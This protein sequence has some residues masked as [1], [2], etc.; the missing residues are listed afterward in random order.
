MKVGVTGANGFVGAHLIQRLNEAGHDV[1]ALVRNKDTV[2]NT[3]SCSV[4]EI[5]SLNGRVHVTGLVAKL[6]GLDILFHLAAHVH[7]MNTKDDDVLFHDVNVAGSQRLF[8]A[9]NTAGVKRFIFL[10]SVKAAGECSDDTPLSFQNN[11]GPEDAYGRSKR[12]AEQT[13][14]S[15]VPKADCSLTI[16]R[17]PF[18]YGWPPV[19]NFKSV[20]N[21]IKKGVP[22]PFASIQNRR[23]MIFVGNLVDALCHASGAQNLEVTPYFIADDGPV[24]TPELFRFTGIAFASPA[25]LF[26]LPIWMLRLV[27]FLTGRSSVIARLTENLEV[28]TAP[29]RRD[30]GWLPPY[31]MSEGLRI[32]ANAHSQSM[33]DRNL[34][35]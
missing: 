34:R 9:A 17:A 24:S 11:P 33:E 10:S 23:H 28:D 26:P 1:T 27:G 5:P 25:R 7:K 20:I 18:V 30:A 29:F 32:C 22:L 6:A 13:L 35:A 2:Q 31:N 3:S 8:E 16:L 4:V 21:A 19:G 12:D 14:Q 15:M